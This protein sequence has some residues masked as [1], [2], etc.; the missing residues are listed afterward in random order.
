ML[1]MEDFLIFH[2]RLDSSVIRMTRVMR[3]GDSDESLVKSL[4]HESELVELAVYDRGNHAHFE[5]FEFRIWSLNS[6]IEMSNL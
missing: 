5:R 1:M 3:L 4:S 6:F 2:E